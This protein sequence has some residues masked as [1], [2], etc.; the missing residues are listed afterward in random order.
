M[1]KHENART[2]PRPLSQAELAAFI[3]GVVGKLRIPK[4]SN[5]LRSVPERLAAGAVVEPGRF[6]IE[7][8]P[9]GLELRERARATPY[10]LFHMEGDSAVP[11]PLPDGYVRSGYG[12]KGMME[13]NL[14]SK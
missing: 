5:P 8:R 12:F 1:S 6:Y 4:A 11:D 9:W 7:R 10:I 2:K 13:V 14:G 3:E